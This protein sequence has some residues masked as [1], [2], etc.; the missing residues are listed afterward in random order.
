MQRIF[1]YGNIPNNNLTPDKELNIL[2]HWTPSYIIRSQ[3]TG[4]VH[5]LKMV[6]FWPTVYVSSSREK[7]LH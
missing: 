3:Y 4:V 1:K 6:H 7:T 2:I 5:F